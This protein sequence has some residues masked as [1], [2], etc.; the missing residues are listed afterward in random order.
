MKSSNVTHTEQ[1]VHLSF[2]FTVMLQGTKS[3]RANSAT[4]LPFGV[5]FSAAVLIRDF[6]S[7]HRHILGAHQRSAQLL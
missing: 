1:M 5:L 2:C 4:A 6:L 3:L 7:P